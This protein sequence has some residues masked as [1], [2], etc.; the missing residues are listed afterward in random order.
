[1]LTEVFSVSIISIPSRKSTF[2]SIQGE[3]TLITLKKF[4]QIWQKDL[5]NNTPIGKKMNVEDI[6][7]FS[8]YRTELF[9]LGKTL[10]ETTEEE[11]FDWEDWRRDKHFT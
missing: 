8:C 4:L 5:P 6:K 2:T 10:I 9:L 7:I 1:M 3:G 11:I